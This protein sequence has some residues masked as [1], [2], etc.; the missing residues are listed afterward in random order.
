MKSV[1]EAI[2]AVAFLALVGFV[3]YM[4]ASPSRIV[5]VGLDCQGEQVRIYGADDAPKAAKVCR[6]VQLH[7]LPS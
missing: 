4:L 3:F 2:V 1:S 7:K 6:S 5:A